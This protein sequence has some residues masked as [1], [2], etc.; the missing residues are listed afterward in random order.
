MSER[1]ALPFGAWKVAISEVT[2]MPCTFEDD[3]ELYARAG[4][5]GIGVWGFKMEAVGP[6]RARDLLRKHDLG[7]ANCI[8]ELNSIMPYVLSPEPADPR[9]RVEAFLPKME[10][11]ARLEPETIVVITGPRG[12]RSPQEALDLCLEGFERIG[13]AASDLGVT[14]GLEPIHHSMEEAFTTICDL[15]STIA[16]LKQ[17]DQPSFKILF[18]TCHLWDTPDLWE[19]VSANI[20]LIAGVHV[21]DWPERARSWAD[22]AFPGEGKLPI[23]DILRNLNAAGFKGYYDVEIF[24]DN[25]QFDVAYPDSLWKLPPEEIV[26]RATGIF[27]GLA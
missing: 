26:D 21:G 11:M 10:R 20:G 22:R 18:D 24:S 3:V 17:L 12:D 13:R 9:R 2:T 19:H 23:L 5:S 16:I 25:G 1:S 14:I 7:A 6:E 27:R 8:P 4:C 15:P